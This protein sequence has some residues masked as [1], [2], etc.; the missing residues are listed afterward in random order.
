MSQTAC[1]AR[2]FAHNESSLTFH[3]RPGFVEEGRLRDH[4]FH[5]GRH[6]DL[7][8]LGILGREFAQSHPGPGESQCF[9]P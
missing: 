1:E 5:G 9:T 6:H 7:V 4:V 8:V 3:R 2:V